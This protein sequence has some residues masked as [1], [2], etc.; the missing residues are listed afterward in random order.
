MVQAVLD[1][2]ERTQWLSPAELAALQRAKLAALLR[3]AS[4][5]T[6]FH[7]GRFPRP[8]DAA[9]ELTAIPVLARRELQEHFDDLKSSAP[10]ADHGV[11]REART[12]GS[13]GMPVRVLKTAATALFW[14]ALT[15]RD[16]LWHRREFAGKLAVIRRRAGG[17]TSDNW[18]AATRG[19]V[20]TGPC[21][22]LEPSAGLDAQLDWLAREAP[23]YLLSYPSLVREL[24]LRSM[25]RG[26]R[27]PSLRGVRTLGELLTAEVR[28]LCREAWGCP[29]E[30]VYSSEE[31]GYIALQCP[32]A[33]HYHVQ[34]E[35]LIVEVVDEAGR[36][37]RPGEVGRVLVTPLDNYAMP[38][39]RYELGDYAELGEPCACGRGLPVLRR[40]VGR[41]R[42][43]FV[44]AAGER[45]W[46]SFGSR[47][48]QRAAPIVQHQFVQKAH[49]LVEARLV[50]GTA[51]TAEQEAAVRK[52]VVSGLPSGVRVV[53]SYP[54]SIERGAGGKFEDF[55]S[56]LAA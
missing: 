7:A 50:V 53:F 13:S 15:L 4:A 10:P 25:A 56:E 54:A 29:L 31:T 24:A 23:A 36:A 48:L 5:T 42:N 22:G 18:G 41:T 28:E 8:E 40:I 43:M 3:H 33:A 30:D 52:I 6:R 32:Q 44:T 19:F 37:C 49:D 26:L 39:L 12:S 21:V 16:H 45:F 9:G 17:R 2:L 27:L 55:R 38:L 35:T 34:A 47:S 14:R 1:A 46:P 11:V 20:A 51:L